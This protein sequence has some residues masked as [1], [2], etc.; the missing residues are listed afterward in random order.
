MEL[1]PSDMS[2]EELSK[3]LITLDFKGKEFKQKCLD[4]LLKRSKA[5]AYYEGME[6]GMWLYAWWKDGVQYV[7]TSGTTLKKA[8]ADIEKEK[9][10]GRN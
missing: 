3:Q 5:D 7:G 9:D 8:I 6:R 4:E 10:H 2:E 1:I